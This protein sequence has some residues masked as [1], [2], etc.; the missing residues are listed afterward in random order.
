MNVSKGGDT[1][2]VV[3][4]ETWSTFIG[5]ISP[6]FQGMRQIHEDFK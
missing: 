1:E 5:M 6:L 4:H 3:N 2:R